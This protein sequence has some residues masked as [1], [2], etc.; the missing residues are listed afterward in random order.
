MMKKYIGCKMVEAEPCLRVIQRTGDGYTAK[1]KLMKPEEFVSHYDKAEEG[2]KVRYADGYESFSPKGVF[3]AAYIEC[4][5]DCNIN[6]Q[7]LIAEE[8]CFVSSDAKLLGAKVGC[9]KAKLINGDEVFRCKVG[10][11]NEASDEEMLE[12]VKNEALELIKRKCLFAVLTA[13]NGLDS[14]PKKGS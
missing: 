1:T 8:E 7:S 12:A 11:V 2:Y 14:V 4:D 13:R 9:F 3:E 5:D 6:P 10:L